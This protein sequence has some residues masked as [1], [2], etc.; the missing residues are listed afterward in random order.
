MKII[1]K[2]QQGGSFLSLFADYTP[3]APSKPTSGETSSAKKTKEDSDKGKLSEKDLF[4][5]LKDVDGLPND[6]RAIVNN[7]QTMYQNA[8]LFGNDDFSTGSLAN[9][10]TQNVYQIKEAN[11]NKKEYDKAYQ[12][13]EKNKG[14]N[15]FAIDERG[16][17]TVYDSEQ[18]LK[19][20]S[21][22]EYLQNQDKY[23][24]LTNSNL[25][26]MRAHSPEL[27]NNNN[28]LDIVS[29]G[30]G[31][32]TVTKMI[33]EVTNKIGT[34]DSS[35]S[36][37]ISKQVKEGMQVI[38]GLKELTGHDDAA[39][40]T[41]DG[42]YKAKMINKTQK[43][44][45]NAALQYIAQSL[46]TNAK[47]LLTLKSNGNV[48][49]LLTQLI[50]SGL[51]ETHSF[52]LDLQANLN[53][54]GSKKSSKDGENDDMKNLK[55][56]TASQ[57]IQGMG[58]RGQFVINPGTNIA[59][60]VNTTTLPLNKKDGTPLEA[61]STL[62][63]VSASQY[64]GILDL[65][66]ASMGGQKINPTNLN[67]VF[68]ETNDIYLVD[69]PVGEDGKTPDMR[70]Q[71][72]EQKRQA[73]AM[74][75]QAGIKMDDQNSRKQ[76]ASEINQIMEECGLPPAVDANGNFGGRWRQ[77]A[78]M[79]GVT[80]NKALNMDDFDSNPYLQ[81]VNDDF[82]EENLL[83]RIKDKNNLKKFDWDHKDPV[84]L[85]HWWEGDYDAFYKGTIWVPVNNNYH[86]A[87]AGTGTT[88]TGQLSDQLS[89]LQQ[90]KDHD[91]QIMS[92]Y[93][94]P[95]QYDE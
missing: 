74:L 31:M 85:F 26:Y 95:S 76:H 20:I 28:V 27:V 59:T 87:L 35:Q 34:S 17:L 32:E 77:F 15:E 16:Q 63:D 4:S 22:N 11:F 55:L 9:M 69:F 93:N 51:N 43:E 66:N 46:P 71:T 2:K 33:Q 81:E 25:L 13:V 83:S 84:S 56:N 54:D 65:Q 82:E 7:I 90:I 30:I 39:G 24:A 88:M 21:V 36:G 19:Q 60:V 12:E 61:G 78:V 41:V 64:A 50:A 53:P 44:Q 29:N 62:Q 70:P 73:D 91:N 38:E 23:H 86:S 68:V 8:S 5:L 1:P 52:D 3:L 48:R 67:H 42:L 45:A 94:N 6:M 18:K 58:D 10:Y 49:E 40:L 79:N 72:L 75:E 92:Q 80:H 47:A 14:L 89:K 57:F 37:Y